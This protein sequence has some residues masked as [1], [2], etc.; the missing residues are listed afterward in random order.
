M[1][2]G[3]DAFGTTGNDSRRIKHE[4]GTRRT[5]KRRRR[6]RVRKIRKRDT[7]TSEPP[8]I[9]SGAQNTKKVPDVLDTA[10]NESGSVKHVNECLPL[11]N[12]KNKAAE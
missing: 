2:M 7:S 8:K 10:K 12:L 6:V 4:N 11:K 1:K 9:S 3:P 5:Q